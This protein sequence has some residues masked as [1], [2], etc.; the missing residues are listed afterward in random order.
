MPCCATRGLC[1]IRR[2]KAVCWWCRQ[3]TE[4]PESAAWLAR[5]AWRDE[6]IE[7]LYRQAWERSDERRQQLFGIPARYGTGI[8]WNE[9]HASTP[10]KN[11]N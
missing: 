7:R 6:Q 11:T 5:H 10:W 1:L 8:D 3:Y 4:Y 9:F 2:I